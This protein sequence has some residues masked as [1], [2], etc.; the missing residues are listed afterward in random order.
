MRGFPEWRPIRRAGR[1]GR[2]CERQPTF[3]LS[4][5][6]DSKMIYTKD[7]TPL[8]EALA[9]AAIQLAE[10]RARQREGRPADYRRSPDGKQILYTVGK[11]KL[12]DPFRIFR[13]EWRERP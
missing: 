9:T 2:G 13:Q 6:R 12:G 5:I 10:Y 1:P 4:Q 11:D 3:A 7:G 8:C